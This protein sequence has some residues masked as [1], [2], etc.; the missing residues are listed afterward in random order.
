MSKRKNKN[1]KG[2]SVEFENDSTFSEEFLR[3]FQSSLMNLAPRGSQMNNSTVMN[4]STNGDNDELK[5]ELVRLRCENER[6]KKNLL[7]DNNELMSADDNAEP[8]DTRAFSNGSE[9]VGLSYKDMRGALSEFDGESSY[10]VETWLEEI[11][12]TA[13]EL[14]WSPLQKLIYAKSALTG[15]AK[16]CLRIRTDLNSFDRFRQ[17]LISEFVVQLSSADVH[18]KLAS[19]NKKESES[20]KDYFLEMRELGATGHVDDLAI[21]KYTIN[22]IADQEVNKFILYGATSV[23]EFKI[24]LS[25][26]EELKAKVT[27]VS[28]E[29]AGTGSS[30][31]RRHNTR[32]F[33]C[34]KMGHEAARCRK[35]ED[36]PKC[37]NCGEHGHMANKCPK[38]KKPRYQIKETNIVQNNNI[39]VNQKLILVNNHKI[40]ATVDTGS[41]LTLTREDQLSELGVVKLDKVE[42]T[43]LGVGDTKIKTVGR[44]V[45]TLEMDDIKVEAVIHVVPK[46]SLNLKFILGNDILRGT[47]IIMGK[48][49]VTIEKLVDVNSLSCLSV[50]ELNKMELNVGSSKYAREIQTLVD[51]YKPISTK[52]SPVQMKILLKSDVPI[53][54]H[55]RRLSPGEKKEVD[56]QIAEWLENGIIGPSSSEYASPVVLVNKKDNTKRICIDYR[57]LNKEIVMDRYPLPLI[58]DQIDRL[59]NAVVF[60]TLDLENGFFHVPVEKDSQKYT[61]FV[62]PTGH[63]EFRRVPFGLCTSPAVFQRFIN[64]V[65]KELVAAGCILIYMDDIII[66]SRTEEEG[67]EKLK[68]VLQVAGEY[69]LKLKWKK[70]QFLCRR[71]EYLGH[72]IA[73]GMVAPSESKTVAVSKFPVP[74]T[75]RQVQS[76]LGLTGYFRK[77]IEDYSIVAKPITD[78]L[79]K[80]MKFEFSQK[81]ISSFEKLKKLLTDKPILIIFSPDRETELHTDASKIGFGAILMQKSQVDS[82][83]HPVYFYSK[84]TTP[85]QA[86]YCSYELEVLAIVGALKKLRV[87]LLGIEFKIVTDCAAFKMTMDRK[88]IVPRI[89]GWALMLQDYQYK[90][91]HRP[92]LKMRHVDALSRNPVIMT[93]QNEFIERMQAGQQKDEH[94]KVIIKLLEHG[95]YQK[96]F[97]ERGILFKEDD[98]GRKLLVVPKRMQQEIVKNYHEEGHFG[99]KKMVEAIQREYF[100][101]KLKELCENCRRNCIAC[102]LAE[103]KSGKQEGFLHPIEKDSYPLMTYHIDH[104]GPMCNTPKQYKFIF[105]VV[106]AFAKFVWLYPVKTLTSAE[107]VRK[108]EIQKV[109][110]GNPK[111]IIADRGTAFTSN[112]FTQYCVDN[113]IQLSLITTGIPRGNGQVERINRIII[114]ALTKLSIDAPE[115][116]YRHTDRLQRFLNAT[117]QRSI[118]T[119]PFE[120]MFGIKIRNPEDRQIV[121]AIEAEIMNDFLMEREQTRMDARKKIQEVQ[122]ENKRTYNRR[123]KKATEYE[124][125]DI[126]AVKRTQ[127]GSGLKIAP[128]F[129]GPY[130]VVEVQQNERYKVEKIGDHSGPF[131]TTSSA[132]HMKPWRDNYPEYD[133]DDDSEGDHGNGGNNQNI[134]D[135]NADRRKTHDDLKP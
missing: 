101:P 6:L 5:R 39:K 122:E 1:R 23:E 91:E 121:E 8:L 18:I 118:A 67:I 73:E 45:A 46:L 97:L 79:K 32:C 100:V 38:P 135:G 56:R 62:I 13:I 10:K 89:A 63:Y 60:T 55:P 108:L 71:I 44:F 76:F 69:G 86:N 133:S 114:P 116:W 7:T 98:E 28:S 2:N 92:G 85:A 117:W 52:R 34:G 61:A 94:L 120:V 50:E 128:K 53:W 104:L 40:L 134:T 111:R 74:K 95:P 25:L 129:L 106:D 43:I 27:S 83:F 47:K 24:K 49:K 103:R 11:E 109:N 130:K 33:N 110:F 21:I 127:F 93:L 12:N 102:I 113:Q 20:L 123:R 68:M 16:K 48:E 72:V 41:D 132:D 131:R 124:I 58:E 87:Y 3:K 105:I 22:G 81:Q 84:K 9:M 82:Q 17:F 54:Q 125:G 59:H 99:V 14:K 112:E 19:R 4:G 115:N 96:F 37:F 126:V 42:T 15:Y 70:C 90:L 107:A 88:E 36:G 77:F 31:R 57:R 80:D 51:Q 64:F 30:E 119:T 65:F 75:I 26:Y 78:L 66:P 35:K 29:K